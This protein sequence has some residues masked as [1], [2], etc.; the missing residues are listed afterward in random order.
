MSL[1]FDIEKSCWYRRAVNTVVLKTGRATPGQ[2]TRNTPMPGTVMFHVTHSPHSCSSPRWSP[3]KHARRHDSSH[4]HHTRRAT[5][6]PQRPPRPT[7]QSKAEPPRPRQGHQG[8]KSHQGP[9]KAWWA[10]REAKNEAGLR[11]AEF[12]IE[13]SETEASETT[14]TALNE[15]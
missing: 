10:C 8:Q 11:L 15:Y 9:E 12:K 7:E 2:R 14:L 6:A 3:R 4:C 5:K 13:V 1:S